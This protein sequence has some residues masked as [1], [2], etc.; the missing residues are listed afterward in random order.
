MHATQRLEVAVVKTL[1][2]DGQARDAGAAKGLEAVLLKGAGVGFQ[3]D[4][5]VGLQRQAG[6]DIAQQTVNGL[7]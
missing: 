3:C 1:H 6:A 5:A 2:A 4:F 7:R